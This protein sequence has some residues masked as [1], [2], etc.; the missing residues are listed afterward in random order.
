MGLVEEMRD[1]FYEARATV[2]KGK[3]TSKIA[4]LKEQQL[5]RYKSELKD[6]MYAA[7]HIKNIYKN[8]KAY[9]VNHSELV[10]GILTKAIEEAG[11]LVPDADVGGI[12]MVSNNNSVTIVNGLGQDVN[13]REGSGYRALLGALIRYACLKAQPSSL[14]FLLFDEYFFTLSDITSNY[15]REV[16]E[17][18]KDDI[19]IVII[20]Q[21]KHWT[22]GVINKEFKFEKD[23]HKI[24]KVEEIIS[25]ENED[26]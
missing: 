23:I 8:I 1:C 16:L 12:H 5:E 9:S 26:G 15:M 13:G 21:R 25:E 17:K 6:L 10:E 20:E 7:E 2:N 22:D 19:L 4:A 11:V 14:K 3:E 18:M 24:T